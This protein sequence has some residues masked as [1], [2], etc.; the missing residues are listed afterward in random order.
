MPS[1][2]I[3]SVYHSL[4]LNCVG[5]A[6]AAARKLSRNRLVKMVLLTQQCISH[7]ELTGLHHDFAYKLSPH[8]L[9]TNVPLS[10]YNAWAGMV[11]YS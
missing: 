4:R 3:V 7:L 11:F 2:G 9:D 10:M 5:N 6:C 8:P 1:C